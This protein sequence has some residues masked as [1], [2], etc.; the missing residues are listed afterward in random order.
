[1]GKHDKRGD[2]RQH[3][4]GRQAITLGDPFDIVIVFN[5]TD[6]Q[7]EIFEQ[8]YR[9][10]TTFIVFEVL[11][12]LPDGVYRLVV[13]EWQSLTPTVNLLSVGIGAIFCGGEL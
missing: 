13:M 3:Q 2:V 6:E 7:F 4:Q 12:N 10:V 9:V 1:L 8:C 11:L 5:F